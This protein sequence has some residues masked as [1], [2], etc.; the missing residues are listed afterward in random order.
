MKK[1]LSIL[2]SLIMAF[3]TF[4]VLG[5]N[6]TKNQTPTYTVSVSSTSGGSISA[7]KSVVEFGEN[8]VITIEEN[9]G[10]VLASLKINGNEVEVDGNA[11][12][13]AGAMRNYTI[14][15]SFVKT[16]VVVTFDKGT[17]AELQDKGVIYGGIFGELPVPEVVL[18]KRFTGW[19]NA[20]GEKVTAST[21]VSGTSSVIDLTSTWEEVSTE[22]KDLLRPFTITT[23][24][25]DMAATNYGLVWHTRTLPVYPVVFVQE[26]DSVDI[27]TAR[28]I[29]ADYEYWFW[30]EYVC[31]AV[32]D[33][34]EFN[35][36]YTAIMGDL[37]ADV[38]SRAYTFTTREEYDDNVEFIFIT[39]TQENYL[40]EN[41][42]S[43]TS[44]AGIGYL[45]TTYSSQVLKEATTHF[46]GTD[47]ITHG[48]DMVNY[49][50]EAKYWEQMMGS[51]DEF[52][53]HYPLM[54]TTGNHSEPLWYA[55]GSK[56]NI[57][58]KMFNVDWE[59]DAHASSGMIYSFNYG[60]QSFALSRV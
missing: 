29:I 25:H 8:V 28:R 24:Y 6:Q 37:S 36:T 5:C 15:A 26:G 39:D 34:L 52:L 30:D 33:N 7:N 43:C 23:A 27:S 51:Y 12:T 58:N 59:E 49:G 17:P 14:S 41:M 10:Y 21:V 53:F 40:I 42:A 47:F 4:T 60:L 22:E 31:N 2:L 38:W 18:G 32:I 56:D 19:V 54:V 55:F 57:E 16:D 48:G 3:G 11:Y 35:T 20:D 50:I 13:I 45:G 44:Y 9:S 1:L 46:P